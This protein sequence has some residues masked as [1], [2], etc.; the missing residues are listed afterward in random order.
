[1]ITG[2]FGQQVTQFL[3]DTGQ[4]VKVLQIAI[5]DQFVEQGSPAKLKEEVGLDAAFIVKKIIVEVIG[6]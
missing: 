3:T 1:M 5:P 4:P 6:R 2:G